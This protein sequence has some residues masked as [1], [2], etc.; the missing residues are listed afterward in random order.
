MKVVQEICNFRLCGPS[1]MGKAITLTYG[2][3]TSRKLQK[4]VEIAENC[5]TCK[6]KFWASII[7][8]YHNNIVIIKHTKSQNFFVQKMHV[9]DILSSAEKTLPFID[10]NSIRSCFWLHIK[11]C[12]ASEKM[13]AK[14]DFGSGWKM[15]PDP[16]EGGGCLGTRHHPTSSTLSTN[17]PLRHFRANLTLHPAILCWCF[18]PAGHNLLILNEW[19]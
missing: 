12:V 1:G 16:M 13:V 5:Y 18:T 2:R 19:N 4:L 3:E 7:C 6:K 10:C 8:Y 11:F 9:M 15:V 14:A 17:L